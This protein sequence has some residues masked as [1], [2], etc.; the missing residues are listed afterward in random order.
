[1]KNKKEILFE[2]Y[3]PMPNGGLILTVPGILEAMEEY[4]TEKLTAFMLNYIG[5][6]ASRFEVEKMIKEFDEREPF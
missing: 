3:E 6:G 1:M 2:K 5:R 4:A